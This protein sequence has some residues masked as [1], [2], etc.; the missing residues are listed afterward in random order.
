[1]G[2]HSRPL[3]AAYPNL[4]LHTRHCLVR[5]RSFRRPH[6]REVGPCGVETHS[7]NLL[8]KSA[9]ISTLES[10]REKITIYLEENLMS[11]V[12]KV[13]DVLGIAPV[14]KAIE[15]VT[16]S[17]VGG[18]EAF[19]GKICLPFAE[20]IGLLFQDWVKRKR[21]RNAVTIVEKAAEK[22]GDAGVQAPPRVVF[23][24]L[25]TGSWI[26]DTV[27]QD[28]W[29]G[30]LASSCT[31]DGD[32]DSNLLFVNILKDLTKLQAL[33]LNY[34]CENARKNKFSNGL[35]N[36][37]EFR[38]DHDT[39]K[40]FTGESDIN[41]LDRE[42]DY[43]HDHGL[44]NGGFNLQFGHVELTPQP[45][46]L[47]LYVRCQGSRLNPVEYFKCKDPYDLSSFP[48]MLPNDTLHVPKDH[49]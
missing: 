1:M 19:L 31:K 41:R 38:I 16:D 12:P 6:E 27:V 20:E 46:A 18:A 13:T 33:I 32:D 21:A 39:L 42:M 30:L 29:A 10:S 45:L 2:K 48:G 8:E 23:N 28:M 36:A 24:I 34:S 17:V 49:K 26:E 15:R 47:H 3:A 22:V 44:I 5:G 40:Q 11:E 7:A 43:L 9:S 37:S 4:Q 14:G 35:I 25:E